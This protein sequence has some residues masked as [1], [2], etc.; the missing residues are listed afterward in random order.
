MVKY[1][2]LKTKANI[3]KLNSSVVQNYSRC[4]ISISLL[5]IRHRACARAC[6]VHSYLVPGGLVQGQ[7]TVYSII[8][9]GG[10]TRAGPGRT[11][12]C[13]VTILMTIF[14]T[15]SWT[16]HFSV[17]GVNLA[18]CWL[19]TWLHVGSSWP[20]L[21][22]CWLKLAQVGLMLAQVGSNWLQVASILPQI[23]LKLV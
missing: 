1:F 2:A 10:V 22:S 8:L 11:G 20:K 18:P 16:S 17:F 21:A 14:L 12:L 7:Y 9:R 3:N 13:R 5:Y 6:G 4:L 15:S 19:P 23:G